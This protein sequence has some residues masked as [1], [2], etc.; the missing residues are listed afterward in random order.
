VV[1]S[2]VPSDKNFST[3]LFLTLVHGS[4]SFNQLK[5][6]QDHLQQHLMLQSSRRENLVRTHFGLFV[7]CAEGLEFLKA[8]RKGG[9]LTLLLFFRKP[10]CCAVFIRQHSNRLVTL[11]TCYELCARVDQ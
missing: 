3:V 6:G 8:F 5:A 11:K 10:T 1:P 2:V 7:Q 9:A 4:A